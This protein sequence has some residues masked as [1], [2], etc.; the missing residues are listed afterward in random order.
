MSKARS[1]F[2]TLAAIG[3][4]L[5]GLVAVLHWYDTKRLREQVEVLK[6]DLCASLGT[7]QTV[8][9]LDR[10]ASSNFPVDGPA[11]PDLASVGRLRE[12]MRSYRHTGWRLNCIAYFGSGGRW[13][14]LRSYWDENLTEID[15][16]PTEIVDMTTATCSVRP[17]SSRNEVKVVMRFQDGE[18]ETAIVVRA[19]R[20]H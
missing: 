7:E 20:D 3:L 5:A 15:R 12:V 2:G 9:I 17:G 1:P 18:V 13:W 4:G 16:A 14:H 10:V 6:E 19:R 8:E 11:E